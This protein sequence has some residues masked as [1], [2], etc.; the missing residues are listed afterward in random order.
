MTIIDKNDTIQIMKKQTDIK[1]LS[2]LLK[3][4]IMGDGAELFDYSLP[5]PDAYK[6]VS[7]Q[8]YAIEYVIDGVFWTKQSAKF[9]ND[10]LLRFNLSMQIERIDVSIVA[11]KKD[12]ITLKEFSSSSNLK[13]LSRTTFQV[14]AHKYED[15]VFW[16]LKLFVEHYI[17]E[18]DFIAYDTLFNYA[19]THYYDYVKD[20][21]TLKAKCRSIWNWY[22]DRDFKSDTYIRK[23]TDEE[24]KMSRKDHIKRVHINR[25]NA[26]YKRV[27]N[28]ITGLFSEEKYKK[29]NGNW[30][31]SNIAKD[32]N[33]HRETVSK[34]IKKYE[35]EASTI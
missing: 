35:S 10:I 6:R 20:Y 25:V 15:S 16:G 31:I 24:L 14:R 5:L 1:A 3:L 9:L 34:Y 11:K 23:C 22:Y 2:T 30:H 7:E 19:Y 8:R 4:S 29:K 27:V 13:S 17:K 26:T 21:S 33:I 18:S 12:T 28:A 32:L